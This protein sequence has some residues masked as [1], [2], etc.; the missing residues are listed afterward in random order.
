[1]HQKAY[2][3][4]LAEDV[5]AVIGMRVAMLGQYWCKNESKFRLMGMV[6]SSVMNCYGHCHGR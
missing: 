3:S 2:H 1:M 5:G 6:R 4:G